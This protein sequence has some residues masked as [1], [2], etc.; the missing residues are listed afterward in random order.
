MP[1]DLVRVKLYYNQKL[2]EEVSLKKGTLLFDAEKRHAFRYPIILARLNNE[3]AELH[4][5]IVED[6]SIEFLDITSS[7]GFRAYQNS[8]TFMM[9]HAV[10][11]LFGK[12]TRVVI[13]HSINKNYYCHIEGMNAEPEMLAAIEAEMNE[14]AIR[15]I[16]FE[17]ISLPVEEAR[18]IAEDF[19]LCDKIKLLQY[20]RTANVNFYK[21]EEF[22]DYF[23]GYMAPSTGCVGKFGLKLRDN[24]FLLQFPKSSN[25]AEMLEVIDYAKLFQI[26][27]ESSQWAN[28]LHAGTVG[29]LNDIISKGGHNEFVRINEALHEKKIAAIADQILAGGKKVVLVAGPSSSGKTT[30]A[31]RLSI[32]LRVNGLRPHIIS[33]D[34]YFW[35]A[36]KIIVDEFGK[37]NFEDLDAIDVDSINGDL[38]K[39]LA[40][41]AVQ[42]P[43][44][45]FTKAK[46]EYIGPLLRLLPEDVLIIEGIHG[47][48][49]KISESVPSSKKFKVFISA[50]TQINI[51]DHNRIPTT[52]TRLIR[53]M[54]RDNRTRGANAKK[55]LELWPSVT[56][57]EERNIFPFQED[58]GCMFN[59]ALV[60]EMCV[61]KQYADPLLF[62]IDRSCDEYTEARRLIKFLDSFIVI[63]S[64]DVPKNS[65]LREFIGG[66]C[67]EI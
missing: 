54:V 47:M 53:R 12:K 10:K 67:F 28:I 62:S 15:D 35:G 17:K 6:C 37:P 34:N 31:N 41:G 59:S 65:I 32:Q 2:L 11:K 27:G 29:A 9:I 51:D 4:N 55:T 46:R 48:N 18:K 58:A 40:G 50:M 66:G 26:F 38:A 64:E 45:D 3:L 23:Y 52:D 39:L 21:L 7:F 44:F 49:E 25:P 61:L 56:R 14:L 19:G 43:K 20:R 42:L 16:K 30:F 57:G 13:N 22:Y 24:G 5:K 1:N 33:L 63:S 60:Y 8:V 36:Q